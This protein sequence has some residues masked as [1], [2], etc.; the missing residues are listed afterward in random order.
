MTRSLPYSIH[1]PVLLARTGNRCALCHQ[2]IDL[3]L[4]SP[5]PRSFTVDHIRPRSHGGCD[6]DF[7][8][9]AAH[10]GCNSSKGNR[11]SN[12]N[13]TNKLAR[14][15]AVP[16]D[17]PRRIR[18][19]GAPGVQRGDRRARHSGPRDH[20]GARIHHPLTVTININNDGPHP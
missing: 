13:R 14:L 7:N 1:K 18:T 20:A 8:R 2:T 11:S 9:Q 3:T 4:G 15:P 12:G 19:S 5:H 17:D 16:A 10:L 6:H